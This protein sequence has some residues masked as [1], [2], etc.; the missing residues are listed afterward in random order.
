[1]PT[2]NSQSK[3]TNGKLKQEAKV[4]DVDVSDNEQIDDRL[5]ELDDLLGEP[6]TEKEQKEFRESVRDKKSKDYKFYEQTTPKLPEWWEEFNTQLNE[7]GGYKYKNVFQFARAKGKNEKERDLIYEMIGPE[8]ERKRNLKVPWLGDWKRRRVATYY[9]PCLP[10]N[11]KKLAKA[12]REKL[13]NVEAIRSTAPYLVQELAQYS[14]LAEK[15]N[16]LFGEDE[17]PTMEKVDR[18]LD[19]QIKVTNMKIT[20]V[21]KYW[22]AHGF[23]EE[24]PEAIIRLNQQI[25]I[26]QMNGGVDT[27]TQKQIETVKLAR[28]LLTHGENFNL[29]PLK[30]KASYPEPDQVIDADSMPEEQKEHRTNGKGKVQ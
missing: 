2:V 24:D 28:Q 4:I 25:N 29:P 9:T 26:G 18:F 23:N 30:L 1:M 19:L 21:T 17:K 13:D 10:Y 22:N 3:P 6:P 7:G 8:P 12:C 5:A 20:L 16:E 11:V 15:I 14:K 27:M